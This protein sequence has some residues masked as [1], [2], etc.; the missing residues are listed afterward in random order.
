VV[1]TL[2]VSTERGLNARYPGSVL[3]RLY[4]VPRKLLTESE[5]ESHVHALTRVPLCGGNAFADDNPE[6]IRSYRLDTEWLTVPR[7]YGEAHFGVADVIEMPP[8][9]PARELEAKYPCLLP[10]RTDVP[11]EET[12]LQVRRGVLLEAMN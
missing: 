1:P 5:V 8:A 2:T 4:R 9:I 11:Q 12:V 10:F 7:F 6:P 3:R